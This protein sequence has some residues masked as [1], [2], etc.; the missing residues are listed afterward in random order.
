MALF[1]TT[2]ILVLLAVVLLQVSRR[3][4]IPYPTMLALAGVAVAAWPWAPDVLIE[5]HLALALFIAP[6]LL[7]AAFDMPP[8]ELWRYSMPLV[9]L[10]GVAVVLTTAAVAWTAVALSGMPL[11]AAVALGAIVAPPDAAAAIAVLSRFSLPRR[12]VTV[13]KGES[14]LNDAVALL[15][16]SAAV[17]AASA[18]DAPAAWVLR[19]GFAVPGG[20]LAGILL[21]KIF[22]RFAS[23]LDGTEGATLL[24]FASVFSIWVLADRLGLSAILCVV[25]YAMTIARYAPERQSPIDRVHSYSVWGT[26]VFLLNVLAFLLLGLQARAIVARLDPAQ[27][28]QA[29]AF[30]S[31][32][33]AVVIVVRFIWVFVY[34]RM[35]QLIS[36]P[37]PTPAQALVVSWCGMRGLVTLAVALALPAAFPAR[38]LIV[39]SALA[40]VLGTLIL[41][42]LTLG[43]LIRWLAI[44]PDNSFNREL[45]FA[46]RTLMDSAMA[47][48]ADESEERVAGIRDEYEAKRAVAADVGNPRASIEADRLRLRAIT[49]QRQALADLRRSGRIDDDVFHTLEQEL[50]WAELAASPPERYEIIEN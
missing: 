47:S 14:L 28:W 46:R 13:L 32:V 34:N 23:Y 27:L 9:A 15:I 26:V 31:A 1:E 4:A 36:P 40:V 29:L 5:P 7:D 48:L 20:L 10:A 38:D 6:I 3:L 35:A 39:I 24:Q 12:M 49:G 43:P 19:L 41:Q 17:T 21:G 33:L 11:A 45:S 44:K 8:R 50:D 30:A 25:A 22:L 37:Q 16:F 2:L 42:G 18:P